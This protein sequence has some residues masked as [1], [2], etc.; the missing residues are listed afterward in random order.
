MDRRP[1][2]AVFERFEVLLHVFARLG[3]VHSQPRHRKHRRRGA[4][5]LRIAAAPPVV[6]ESAVGVLRIAKILPRAIRHGACESL[7]RVLGEARVGRGNDLVRTI[8]ARDIGPLHGARGD[9]VRALEVDQVPPRVDD[10][11]GDVPSVLMGE[12]LRRRGNA[13]SELEA[14]QLPG[15]ELHPR[16]PSIPVSVRKAENI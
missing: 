13:L 4:A 12:G 2:V 8:A 16:F 7:R 15:G 1:A 9:S 11:H 14:Q 6:V 3:R 10:G 5:D